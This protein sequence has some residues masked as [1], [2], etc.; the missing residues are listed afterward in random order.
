MPA[1]SSIFSCR[2]LR[3]TAVAALS[4]ASVGCTHTTLEQQFQG[5]EAC[6]IKDVYLDANTS[7]ATGAYFT[8]RRLQPCRLDEAAFYC[9]KD[10]FYGLTVSEVVIPYRGPFSVHAV[11]LEESR[12]VVE[13]RLRA[14]FKGIAF[15]RDDG[16]TPFLIDDP[17][18][19]GR[20]VFYCDRHSE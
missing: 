4:V 16:A 10:T 11:Y 5:I 12:P 8:E 19:P 3:A 6:D 15:N 7:K 18:Q 13:Q 14:R 20:T 9:I 17:K 2:T 1:V